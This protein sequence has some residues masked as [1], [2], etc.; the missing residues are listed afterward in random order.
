MIPTYVSQ[1]RLVQVAIAAFIA[2]SLP[3]L[4]PVV[5]T[6]TLPSPSAAKIALFT[7][8]GAV[9]RAVF[10]AYPSGTRSE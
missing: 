3:F 1:S 6:G 10:L 9:I 7:V 2:A 5:A 8:I 4:E